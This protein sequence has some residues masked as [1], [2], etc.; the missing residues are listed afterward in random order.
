M[1]TIGDFL[2]ALRQHVF[3]GPFLVI[4]GIFST[5]ISM[6]FINMNA[7]HIIDYFILLGSFAVVFAGVILIFRQFASYSKPG[8]AIT[9][10]EGREDESYVVQKL[11]KNFEVLRAQ[12]NHGFMLSSVFMAIGLILIFGS[13]FSPSLGLKTEGITSLGIF[14][15]LITEIISETALMLYKINFTRLNETSDRLDDAWRVLAAFKLTRELPEE[16][17]AVATLQLISTLAMGKH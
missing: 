12:T 6:K 1:A 8:Q 5:Y 2:G 13:I 3:W 16:K 9:S 7:P 4:A 14:S 17:R 15:G 10:M 11:H